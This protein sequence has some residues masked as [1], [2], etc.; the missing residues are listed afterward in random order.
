MTTDLSY[1]DLPGYVKAHVQAVIL[2]NFGSKLDID[3][4]NSFYSPSSNMRY[5]YV[6]CSSREVLVCDCTPDEGD[7]LLET[8]RY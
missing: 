3:K 6:V 8:I 2:K 4:N 1:N 7:M 5:G